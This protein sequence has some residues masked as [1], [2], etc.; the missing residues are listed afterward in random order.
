LGDLLEGEERGG[1][2]ED[3]E[4]LQA[5]VTQCLTKFLKSQLYSHFIHKLSDFEK[6]RHAGPPDCCHA[7]PRNILRISQK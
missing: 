2:D 4:G 3:I 6:E 7:A 5:A 1:G